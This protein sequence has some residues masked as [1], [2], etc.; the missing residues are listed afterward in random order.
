MKR[1]VNGLIID[2][3]DNPDQTNLIRWAHLDI[4]KLD[5]RFYIIFAN[6]LIILA[7]VMDLAGSDG[8]NRAGMTG[9]P[10]RMLIEFI[11]RSGDKK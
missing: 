4:G 9:R 10:T 2:G 3:A 7:G 11:R 6:V 1:F 5:S 8:Y